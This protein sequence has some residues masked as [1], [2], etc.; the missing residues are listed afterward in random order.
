MQY[1]SAIF[2]GLK[3]LIPFFTLLGFV[4]FW[5][6]LKWIGR[7]DVFPFMIGNLLGALTLFIFFVVFSFVFSLV[8]LLPSITV[9]FVRENTKVSYRKTKF[10][11]VVCFV[12]T[13]A[14]LLLFALEVKSLLLIIGLVFLLSVLACYFSLTFKLRDITWQATLLHLNRIMSSSQ[15]VKVKAKKITISIYDYLV[16]NTVISKVIF[17]ALAVFVSLLS[18]FPMLYISRFSNVDK[19]SDWTQVFLVGVFYLLSYFPIIVTWTVRKRDYKARIQVFFGGSIF[20]LT[21]IYSIMYPVINNINQMAL[22]SAG[23]AD[24]QVHTFSFDK[25]AFSKK[26]FPGIIWGTSQEIDGRI[27]VD[28]IQVLSS[29]DKSLICPSMIGGLRKEKIAT[30]FIFK[31]EKPKS[32][33]SISK[34]CLLVDKSESKRADALKQFLVEY[35]ITKA[36]PRDKA[37]H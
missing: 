18:L 3:E 24:W 8:F 2:K 35:K 28:G 34:Y 5:G 25:N 37:S 32:L 26:Y 27:I 13:I 14:I 7:V 9:G 36:L 20:A 4:S 23:L 1:L 21:A 33:D 16:N 29:G 22:V 31:D 11:P 17:S 10:F 30:T 12:N 19:E 15:R 6:Y